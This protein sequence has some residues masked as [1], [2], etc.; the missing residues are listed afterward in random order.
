M[1]PA[2][3][4]A[5]EQEYRRLGNITIFNYQ[6]TAPQ[7]REVVWGRAGGGTLFTKP[8][9]T[10]AVPVVSSRVRAKQVARKF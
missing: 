6:Q 3:C 7:R 2:L 1:T 9:R 8:I 10:E 5:S 4:R